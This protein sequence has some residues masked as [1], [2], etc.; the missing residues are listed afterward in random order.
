MPIITTDSPIWKL[1]QGLHPQLQ[2]SFLDAIRLSVQF[3][4]VTYLRLNEALTQLT[5]TTDRSLQL[6]PNALMDAWAII[7][8]VHRLRTL[9]RRLPRYKQLDLKK[10]FMIKK[11]FMMRTV[12]VEQMRNSFQHLVGDLPEL[13]DSD[14]P[15]LGA[16]TWVRP[17]DR[18]GNVLSV[19]T[20][21]PG[22][23]RSVHPASQVLVPS[24]VPEE[25]TQVE[26]WHGDKS[27]NVSMLHSA[28]SDLVAALEIG[29]AK[30]ASDNPEA[31]CDAM[32]EVHLKLLPVNSESPSD[33]QAG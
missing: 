7:D 8:A 11:L 12:S 3:I 32:A 22:Q 21:I 14:L 9:V 17:V 26:L 28:V 31:P 18:V 20:F 16:L 13:T 30:L 10:L 27:A 19:H 15:V 1:P 5:L 29:L 23:L 4:D 6:G 24:S 25:T 33:S 2:A